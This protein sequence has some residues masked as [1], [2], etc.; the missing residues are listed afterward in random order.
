MRRQGYS[1]TV[2]SSMTKDTLQKL[3]DILTEHVRLANEMN[4]TNIS[5]EKRESIQKRIKELIRK[6]DHMI[7]GDEL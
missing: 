1:N 2:I 6:R 4:R 3:E 7:Y 5:G